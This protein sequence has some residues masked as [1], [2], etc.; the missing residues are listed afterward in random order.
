MEL[1]FGK[2]RVRITCRHCGRDKKW[3]PVSESD[4]AWKEWTEI[5]REEMGRYLVDLTRFT[6]LGNCPDCQF[7]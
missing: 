2:P 4:E 1:F 7:H 3:V 5:E 6:H